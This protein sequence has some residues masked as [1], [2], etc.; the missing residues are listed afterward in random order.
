MFKKA[1]WGS[2]TKKR[3][4][5]LPMVSKVCSTCAFWVGSRETKPNGFIEIHPYS[6]GECQGGRYKHLEMAALATC[7]TWEPWA[8]MNNYR[9]EQLAQGAGY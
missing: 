7:D 9:G 6:K 3:K 1:H 8:A 4:T 5:A 2:K